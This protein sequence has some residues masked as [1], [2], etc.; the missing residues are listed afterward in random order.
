[1]TAWVRGDLVISRE[2]LIERSTEL[3]VLVADH[4]VGSV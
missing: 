3:F 2:E 1:M 4:V